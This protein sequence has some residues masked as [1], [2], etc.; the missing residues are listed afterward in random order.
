M[1]YSCSIQVPDRPKVKKR[2]I[3]DS[4]D[5]N[6]EV[7]PAKS[8]VWHPSLFTTSINAIK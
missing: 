4:D 1:P 3:L 8:G 6:D 7:S 5:E 2:R